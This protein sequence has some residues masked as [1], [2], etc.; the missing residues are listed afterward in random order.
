MEVVTAQKCPPLLLTNIYT[1]IHTY[2]HTYIHTEMV[3]ISWTDHVRCEVLQRVKEER[4]NL[5]KT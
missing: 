2:I 5:L 3:K 1:H 4:N